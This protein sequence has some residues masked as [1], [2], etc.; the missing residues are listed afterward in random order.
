[1]KKLKALM[2]GVLAAAAFA[3][4][5]R[6]QLFFDNYCVFGSFQVCASVRVFSEGNTLR[7]RVWNLGGG[8]V[9]EVPGTVGD[10]HTMT[11]IGLYHSGTP[12]A[13]NVLSYSVTHV[14]NS[15]PVD[16]VDITE[17]WTPQGGQQIHNLGGFKLELKEGTQGN[18]GII[19]CVDPGGLLKWE[20][21]NSFD[22]EPY[23][24]FTFNLDTNFALPGTELR[25]H[26]QQIGPDAEL[27]LKC[28]TGGAGYSPPCA[29]VPEPVTSLLLA[30]GLAGIGAAARRR[31][32][33][34]RDGDRGS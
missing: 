17:Y 25:W 31:R 1:M 22:G 13:G 3:T 26:S 4:P 11:A 24:E 10:A 33:S 19:G 27:S 7:M 12:W 23:V 14:L 15:D 21:C 28:D 8:E 34:Q 18:R 5:V 32:P 29:V 30:S 6:A 16:D 20:T 9:P 2:I